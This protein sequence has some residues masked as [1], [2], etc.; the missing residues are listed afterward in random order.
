MVTVS[1][2]HL[3]DGWRWAKQGSLSFTGS[4]P[5]SSSA[6][7]KPLKVLPNSH[8]A[9]HLWVSIPWSVFVFSM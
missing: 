7:T 6:V 3:T 8:L 2:E 4:L 1:K 9:L 5:A